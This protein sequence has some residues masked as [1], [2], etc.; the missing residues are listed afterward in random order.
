MSLLLAITPLVVVNLILEEENGSASDKE[1]S[2]G[3]PCKEPG[4]RL[5][6]LASCLQ[7]LGG[8]Q[9]LLTPPDSVISAANIAAAKAMMFISGIKAGNA[10]FDCISMEDLPISCCK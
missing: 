6:D 5:R 4:K 1:S 8:Y 3:K 2:T 10:Y 7:S 9:S